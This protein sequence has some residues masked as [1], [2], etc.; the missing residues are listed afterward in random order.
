MARSTV[1][2]AEIAL[3]AATKKTLLEL[4]AAA[5]Q[6]LDITEWWVEFDGTSSSAEPA[7]VEVLRKTATITGA[8]SP[9]S[10]RLKDPADGTPAYTVKHNASAEGTDGDVLYRHEVHP[11]GGKHVIFS[12]GDEIKVPLSGIIAIAVTAPAGVNAIAGFGVSE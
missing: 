11:T 8:A 6:R 5:A 12:A 7:V 1:V 10:P 3:V 4:T 2:T 9:P